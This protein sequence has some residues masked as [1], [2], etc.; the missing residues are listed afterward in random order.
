MS[1][2]KVK[3]YNGPEILTGIN[4]APHIAKKAVLV[5]TAKTQIDSGIGTTCI[6]RSN[7]E[8]GFR[9]IFNKNGL[10]TYGKQFDFI[11][12]EKLYEYVSEN[13]TK[14]NQTV[15]M[16]QFIFELKMFLFNQT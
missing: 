9:K 2:K 4:V 13:K 11:S 7:E 15:T 14:W 1:S 6:G 16:P 12:S 5:Q 8:K 10:K 3:I